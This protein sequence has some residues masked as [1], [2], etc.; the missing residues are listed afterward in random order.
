MEDKEDKNKS[1]GGYF[2]HLGLRQICDIALGAAAI[3]LIV[4]LFVETQVVSAIGFALFA[5]AS[6]VS[7]VRCAVSLFRVT[8]STPE[9][10]NALVGLIAMSAVFALSLTGFILKIMFVI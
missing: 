9:Y 1:T 6:A 10:R 4:G 3:L 5:A 2:S 8:R 7:A